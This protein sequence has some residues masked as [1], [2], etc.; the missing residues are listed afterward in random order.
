MA[1]SN[2]QHS[3]GYAIHHAPVSKSKLAAIDHSIKVPALFFTCSAVMWLLIGTAFA[4]IASFSL[5]SPKLLPD[6]EWLTFG[7]VRSA[8]LN[9]V[10]YGWGNNVVYAVCLWVMAR[11]CQTKI[12]YPN[13]L[14][15]AGVFWNLGITIGVVSILAGNLNAVEWLEMPKFVSPILGLSY[16]LIGVWAVISFFYRETPYVYVSQ[17]YLLAGFFWFPWIYTAVQ[18]MVIWFPAQ[19]TVQAVTNWWFG[20]NALG[21]WYTPMAI[22]VIYYLIPKVLGKPIHSYYLS[23]IGFWTLALFYN[24]A[25]VH[26]LI[27]G[28]IPVWLV[29][30]G[31]VASVMMVIPVLVTAVNHHMTVVGSFKQVWDSPTLR[32][33]VFGAMSYTLTSVLGSTMALREVNQVTHFTHF[34]VGHAHHG[35]Y[36]FFTMVMFGSLYYMIP[37]MLNRE[38]PSAGLIHLHF[39]AAGIGITIY[40]TALSIGGWIQ[41][42]SMNNPDIVFIEVVRRT[43]PW[44]ISRSVGGSLMALGHVAFAI[45]F[46]WMLCAKRVK[47]GPT[48]FA[49]GAAAEPIKIIP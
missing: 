29:S 11:L 1:I 26:H 21:L 36:A 31:V 25:G 45:N 30:A 12:R 44:L 16:V 9:S 19:G 42:L 3:T 32:F 10:A 40:V 6:W 24:W 46:T 5:H 48:M 4:L 35:I 38:W 34:T 33:V 8:H 37:R 39:W 14:I 49:Q 28:P 18:T 7:R 47:E 2:I 43:V 13:I 15:T 41:G 23:V 27:G 20:H 22:A 17:W